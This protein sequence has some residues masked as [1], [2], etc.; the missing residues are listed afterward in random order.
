[1]SAATTR[2]AL[3]QSGSLVI[4]FALG[5]RISPAKAQGG[6]SASAPG[7]TVALD[8]VD[9]FLAIGADGKVTVFSGKVDLGTGVRTALTQMAAE[10]L[11]VPLAQVTVIQGDTAL[12]PDQGPTYGSLSVQ[13][14]GVQIRQ[15]AA[16][17]RKHLLDLAS[18]RLN[19]PADDLA[20]QDGVVRPKAGGQGIGYGDLLGGRG[21]TLKVDKEVTTKN[22]AE[23]RIVGQSVPRLDIPAKCTGRFTYMQD[24]SVDG[25]LHARVVRPPAIGATLRSMDEASVRDIPG[26]VKVVREGNFLA[27]VARNEWAAIKASQ[28][29]KADW[30]DWRGLPEQVRLWE[31]VRGTRVTK[32][33][34]TS[35]VGN[36]ADAMLGGA[37]RLSA[38]YDFPIHTHGSIGP[39]C[40]VAQLRDGQLTVWTASQMTHALRKQIAAMM[41]MPEGEVRCIYLEG[42]GCYGRNGHEDA[43]GD[44]ALLTRAMGGQPVRVQ[45]SRQDE[46]GWDPK[47]P[48]TLID[49]RAALDDKGNIAA[50][51][52][53]FF[54]PEGAAGNV[55]LVPAELAGLPHESSMAP[56]N[57]IQ[58][59]A[60]PYTVPAVRTTCHRL[61]ETPFK[62]SWIR[63]PG[64]MQN[65]YANEAFMDELAA[66]AGVDPLE[67]RLRHLRDPRGE[68]LLRRLATLAKWESRPSPQRN[69]GG[70]VMRGRGMT[71]VKY[72]LNRTYIGTVAEVEV[73]RS[74]GEI[75]VPRFV[76]VHD[77]GQVIN[78][79]GLRNQIEGNVVQTVSRTLKEELTFD[80]SMVTSLDWNSYPIL[81]FP[82]VPEVVI[83]LLD[84]PQ[85]RPWGAGE[86]SAAAIPSAI[87]NAVFDATG[88]R[89][90]SVPYTPARVKAALQAS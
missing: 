70:D 58:N 25:M 11:D 56:G 83:E 46:H 9:G 24:F 40:A 48:P 30:S 63:T 76:V 87:S 59:S 65:T 55:P 80:R 51:E 82:E 77:C 67:F 8:E 12:T 72:E 36:P 33:D 22:P 21:F 47:G 13:N 86:P 38:T 31:H 42:S 34:V 61:A 43:A 74:T 35:S 79:D 89:L 81:T 20:V 37:K 41:R 85:E 6:S 14:G 16:T 50:W 15:A 23:F 68:E 57:I 71:Y 54:I 69:G 84:R 3:L 62:P 7:K 10:E 90:R 29:L 32:D 60:L 17:A 1:M 73:N 66:A 44:A 64:R 26:A 78:P 2:R 27:V 88:V 49:L 39:S 5:H 53:E 45:W 28:T 19:L 18:R 75:R 52:S 4:G